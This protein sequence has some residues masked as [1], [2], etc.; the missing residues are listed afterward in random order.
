[1]PPAVTVDVDVDSPGGKL[2][3]AEN[4]DVNV[5]IEAAAPGLIAS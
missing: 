3:E 1:M 4:V 2:D 5:L